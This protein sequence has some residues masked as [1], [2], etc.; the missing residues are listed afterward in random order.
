MSLSATST[1]FLDPSRVGDSPTAPSSLSR[2][3]TAPSG[4]KRS[5]APS[6]MSHGTRRRRAHLVTCLWKSVSCL[7]VTWMAPPVV[8]F[9]KPFSEF[10]SQRQNVCGRARAGRRDGSAPDPPRARRRGPSRSRGS[11]R[12]VD[13]HDLP[14]HLGDVGQGVGWQAEAA[15]VQQLVDELLAQLVHHLADQLLPHLK[16]LLVLRGGRGGKAVSGGW[17]QGQ[18]VPHSGTNP[19]A[20]PP[21]N[22]GGLVVAAVTNANE[23]DLPHP[24]GNSRHWPCR[25]G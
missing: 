9:G 19:R 25:C 12:P 8:S 3:L 4:Q 17:G 11:H 24:R 21:I 2:S 5:P 22:R 20:S 14:E 7:C 1:R 16:V 15:R 18:R 6:P 10:S 23:E 13:L